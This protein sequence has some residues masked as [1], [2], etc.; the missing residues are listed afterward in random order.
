[1]GVGVLLRVEPTLIY[2][3]CRRLSGCQEQRWRRAAGSNAYCLGL[4]YQSRTLDRARCGRT[5]LLDRTQTLGA[6]PERSRLLRQRPDSTERLASSW[7]CPAYS[8]LRTRHQF[9]SL[10]SPSADHPSKPL[11]R[12]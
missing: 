6:R 3:K 4:A 7:V 12:L 8:L 9:L 1:M 5:L 11:Q 10:L 2:A